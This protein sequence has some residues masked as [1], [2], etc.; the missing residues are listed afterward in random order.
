MCFEIIILKEELDCLEKTADDL[1]RR[2]HV[3]KTDRKL[4][5]ESF[6]EIKERLKE[7][8]DHEIYMIAGDNEEELD[9]PE[10]LGFRGFSWNAGEWNLV[11]V[12]PK[13]E[14]I[15]SDNFFE[16]IFGGANIIEYECSLD[17]E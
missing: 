9:H 1:M 11:F 10:T 5:V 17:L 6:K 7:I 8:E 3:R 16:A 14:Y 2:E 12:E 4:I 15:P 13:K